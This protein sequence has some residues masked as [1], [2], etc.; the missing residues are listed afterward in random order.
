[1]KL[2][3]ML[4]FSLIF[5]S[6]IF[7]NE[8]YWEIDHNADEISFNTCENYDVVT[9]NNGQNIMIPGQPAL[10][11]IG[12][13]LSIPPTSRIFSVRI[14]NQEWLTLG[15]LKI[16]PT[17]HKVPIGFEPVIN[18]ED[19]DIYSED[20][21]FPEDPILKFNT[22]IKAGFIIAGTAY[23]PF[24][25]NPVTEELQLLIKGTIVI[26]YFEGLEISLYITEEQRDVFVEDVENLVINAS[27]VIKN[28]PM[29][30]ASEDPAVEYVIIAPEYLC[31]SFIPLINWKNLK[32]IRSEIISKE[33]I[34]SNYSGYDDMEKIREFVKDYHQN[35]GLIYLVLAGDYDN[36]GA[37]L[38]HSEVAF[39]NIADD[40]P[41]DLYFSDIVPY[42]KNW[43]ANGNHIYGEFQRDS[44]DWYSDVYVGRFPV[45]TTQEAEIWID[46]LLCYE[47]NPPVGYIETSLMG[48]AGLWPDSNLF[49]DIICDSIADN[50]LPANWTD[51]KLYE[52]HSGHPDGFVD[53]LDKG[54]HWVHVAAHGNRSGVYWDAA[55][56]QMLTSYMMEYLSN[57]M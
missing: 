20:D 49:G 23:C 39:F 43:D 56:S 44:C 22:G 37:R 40:L 3:I 34:L 16:L 31:N 42:S 8:I 29:I 35:K 50:Y 7:S 36:L 45:N 26:N 6:S 52:T 24:R 27:D 28:S 48:G 19:E 4:L 53:S 51:T 47:Q 15:Y 5:V 9:I 33:W 21:Y 30:S 55:P 13:Q 38:I 57:G 54:F 2:K 18:F 32:G 41:S 11:S 1:M 46:K 25:Y 17:Q 12:I 14:E 10:Q